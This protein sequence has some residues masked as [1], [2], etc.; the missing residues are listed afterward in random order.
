[1]LYFAKNKS[2]EAVFV[3]QLSSTNEKN[4][5][6]TGE[7]ELI[8]FNIFTQRIISFVQGKMVGSKKGRILGSQSSGTSG[9]ATNTSWL[10]QLLYC[11]GHY[12]LAVPKRDAYGNW[13]ECWGIGGGDGSAGNEQETVQNIQP[14]LGGGG[15][16]WTAFLATVIIPTNG[17]EPDPL[18]GFGNISGGSSGWVSFIPP[19]GYV[20]GQYDGLSGSNYEQ[21]QDLINTDP[22]TQNAIDEYANSVG[23]YWE[24][25]TD[26]EPNY[27]PYDPAVDGP[28]TPDGYK[29]RGPEI[30]FYNFRAAN[31][32]NDNGSRYVL[33]V[34]NSGDIVIFPGAAITTSNVWVTGA[35]WTSP[36]GTMHLDNT[37]SNNDLAA[38]E[39]EYGHYLHAQAVGVAWYLK[40]VAPASIYS[41]DHDPLNHQHTWTEKIA[42][43]YAVTY[44]GSNSAIAGQPTRFP[45]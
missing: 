20:P 43:V 16:D 9:Y 42:N 22:V 13:T 6:F 40:Y 4:A 19:S 11:L 29:R 5:L 26:Y 34:S 44:F 31:F 38:L 17:N 23:R 30:Q 33:A 15:I 24:N 7:Y 3:R 35:A 8:D 37:S 25:P 41:A 36:W 1:M 21:V 32:E 12:V 14:D 18:P 27:P 39:H 2:L 10:S 45:R 28:P